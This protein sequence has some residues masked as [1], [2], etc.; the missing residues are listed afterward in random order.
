MVVNLGG[1]FQDAAKSRL[2][3]EGTFVNIFSLTKDIV[4]TCITR[5]VEEKRLDIYLSVSHYCPE[6]GCNGKENATVYDLLCHWAAM[7]GSRDAI[8]DE[9]W[10][11]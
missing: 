2:W 4:A 1:G 11:N 5:L 10:Q 3:Q 6:Y 9:Q 7:F 8:P